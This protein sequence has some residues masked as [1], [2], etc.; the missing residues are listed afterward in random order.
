MALLE[1]LSNEF[2]T[3]SVDSKGPLVR[4]VRSE[5]PFPSIEVLE[6]V[7]ADVIRKYDEI[8]R[9][10]RVLLVDLRAARGRNDSE[11]ED[12]MMKLRSRLYGGFLR[13][14][15]LVKSS[16]GALQINRMV[17]EDGIPRMVMTDEAGLLEYLVRG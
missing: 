7:V 16:V 13:V 8:G 3:I 12:R 6:K 17:N 9:G 2:L 10:Q 15:I 14:G 5:V 1:V 11:F 4:H